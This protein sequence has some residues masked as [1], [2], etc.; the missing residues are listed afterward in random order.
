MDALPDDVLTVEEAAAYLG[1]TRFTLNN[2]RRGN[3]GPVYW[4]HTIQ[5]RIFYSRADLDAFLVARMERVEPE[6]VITAEAS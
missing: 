5:R 2:W 4:K 1:V 6:R 3:I